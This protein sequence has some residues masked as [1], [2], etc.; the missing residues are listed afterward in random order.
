M[1]QVQLR[2]FYLYNF[3]TII[4]DTLRSE[5][6]VLMKPL[7]DYFY[8]ISGLFTPD[9]LVHM[10][11]LGGI[12]VLPWFFVTFGLKGATFAQNPYGEKARSKRAALL[13]RFHNFH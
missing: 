2:A 6:A 4:F 10:A 11:L 3:F 1:L 8:S 9:L 12:V 13:D 5:T 7:A